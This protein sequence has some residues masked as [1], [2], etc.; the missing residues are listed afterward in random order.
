MVSISRLALR[1]YVLLGG[2]SQASH[3][4]TVQYLTYLMAVVQLTF[5]S[6]L[7]QIRYKIEKNAVL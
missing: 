3:I 4:P 1:V 6:K 5:E 2:S 7:R